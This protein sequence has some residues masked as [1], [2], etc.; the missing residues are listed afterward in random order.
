LTQV[1]DRW[2]ERPLWSS[3][4]AVRNARDHAD[5]ILYLVNA[6][7]DPADA[8]YVALEMEILAW[9]AKPVILLLNQT[10]PPRPDGAPTR[11][12]GP[13]TLPITRSSAAR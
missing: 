7:E 13:R 1:W 11:R 10:G 5:V 6:S 3:Q 2:R 8:G 4:Q 9:V 12:D